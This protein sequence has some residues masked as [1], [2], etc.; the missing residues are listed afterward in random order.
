MKRYQYRLVWWSAGA[1]RLGWLDSLGEEGWLLCAV[2]G[3]THIFAKE[4][5]DA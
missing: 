3:C 1:G 4:L 2:D 5:P